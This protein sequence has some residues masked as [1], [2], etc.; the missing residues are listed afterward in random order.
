MGAHSEDYFHQLNGAGNGP[1]RG[2]RDHRHERGRG[3]SRGGR[4]FGRANGNVMPGNH[5]ANGMPPQPVSATL[6]RSPSYPSYSNH[7]TQY[8]GTANQARGWR[9]NNRS[10]STP[11]ED[12]PA[13]YQS[14]FSVPSMAPFQAYTD[15]FFY[16]TATYPMSAAPYSPSA[17]QYSIVG[18]ISVQL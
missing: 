7:Y 13:K 17:E 3:G 4:N 16:D 5:Y 10:N 14:R 18:V 2:E 8:P 6:P 9:Q 15:Q 1:Y 12:N 11:V